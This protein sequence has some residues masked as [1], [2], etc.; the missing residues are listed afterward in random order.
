MGLYV[1]NQKTLGLSVVELRSKM[2]AEMQETLECGCESDRDKPYAELIAQR[3]PDVIQG[4]SS[5]YL[6]HMVIAEEGVDGALSWWVN[7][8][9]EILLNELLERSSDLA[10]TPINLLK[11]TINLRK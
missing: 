2:L 3:L 8:M 9:L 7:H 5:N 6:A 4:Y 1:I 10:N 11:R